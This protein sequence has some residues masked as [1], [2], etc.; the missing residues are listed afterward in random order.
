MMPAEFVISRMSQQ[1]GLSAGTRE[2]PTPA[3]GTTPTGVSLG[4]GRV[5][6][7]FPIPRSLY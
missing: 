7:N 4:S 1:T 2:Q 3:G 5:Y 6:P